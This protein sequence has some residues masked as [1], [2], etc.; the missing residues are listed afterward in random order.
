V[1]LVTAPTEPNEF[2]QP[3]VTEQTPDEDEMTARNVHDPFDKRTPVP[4]NFSI[5]SISLTDDNREIKLQ[6]A[7]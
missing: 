6:L 7:A 2:A 4:P 5:W 3:A 1:L